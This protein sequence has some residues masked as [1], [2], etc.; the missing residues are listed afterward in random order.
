MLCT[1]LLIITVFT[2]FVQFVASE[3]CWIDA[4]NKDRADDEEQ[5]D[6]EETYEY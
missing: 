6:E 1:F 4:G 3:D 2:G 5:D